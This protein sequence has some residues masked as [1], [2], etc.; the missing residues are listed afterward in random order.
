[1]RISK[2]SVS[3]IR[4]TTGIWDQDGKPIHNAIVW[5]DRRGLYGS[6]REKNLSELFSKKTGLVLDPYFSG[7]KVRW[8]LENVE[9][10]E[11]AESGELRFG[12]IDTWLVWNLT[13]VHITDVTNA[14]RP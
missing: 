2:Q 9:E 1:M 14:S 13:V 3:R 5:Q 12:T 10:L 11:H 6:L 4:E 8:L 7:T